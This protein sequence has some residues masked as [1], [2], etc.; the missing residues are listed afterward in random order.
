MLERNKDFNKVDGS[1]DITDAV[2][3]KLSQNVSQPVMKVFPA[4]A[5]AVAQP[6]NVLPKPSTFMPNQLLQQLQKRKAA[7]VAFGGK[8][9]RK[10]KRGRKSLRRAR[11]INNKH[12]YIFKRTRGHAILQ[13]SL[14]NLILL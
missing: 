8:T 9:K 4:A 10:R 1:K 5:A 6:T 14:K 3:N 13:S 7:N 2:I 12:T 11:K